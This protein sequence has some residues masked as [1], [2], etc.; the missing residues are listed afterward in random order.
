ML[1]ILQMEAEVVVSE[2]HFEPNSRELLESGFATI[3]RFAFETI[4]AIRN[5]LQFVVEELP[6]TRKPTQA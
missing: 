4:G 1:A 5:S 6:L 2:I 3:D